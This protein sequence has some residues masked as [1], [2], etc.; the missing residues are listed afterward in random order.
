MEK[1]VILL[2]DAGKF[3]VRGMVKGLEAQ[4]FTTLVV[5]PDLEGLRTFENK[6][7]YYIYYLEGDPPGEVLDYL[8]SE[9]GAGLFH[10]FL[11]GS[12]EEMDKARE[13]LPDIKNIHRYE[14]PINVKVLASEIDSI[15]SGDKGGSENAKK[16]ILLVDDDGVMLRTIKGWLKDDHEVFIANSGSNALGFLENNRVDLILLDYMMP[17]M[18]G[19]DVYMKLHEKPETADIPV[20]FLTARSDKNSVMKVA[21]LRPVKYLLKTMEPDELKAIIADF[22]AARLE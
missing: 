14:R 17:E 4:G 13:G 3:M 5:Y 1:I 16:K 15:M 7:N 20:M 21:E 19:P 11:V 8:N 12:V 2:G 9:T 6:T 22:F 18:S 10:I